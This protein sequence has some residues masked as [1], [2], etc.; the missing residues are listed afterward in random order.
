M[1]VRCLPGDRP[2]WRCSKTSVR[3]GEILLNRCEVLDVKRE[4][5]E[6]EEWRGEV[7]GISFNKS[8]VQ[9]ERVEWRAKLLKT[10]GD[11]Q[12]Y[13][14]N[15]NPSNSGEVQTAGRSARGSG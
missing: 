15:L 8:K 6:G 12:T 13:E 4:D 1:S 7:E 5:D 10:K 9:K 2:A 11:N 14:G 3:R